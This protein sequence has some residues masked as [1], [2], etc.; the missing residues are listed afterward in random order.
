LARREDSAASSETSSPWNSPRFISNHKAR[1]RWDAV[2]KL[3]AVACVL[4]VVVPLGDLLYM[5]AYR[6][7]EVISVARLVDGTGAF[8]PGLSNA[9]VGT[10]LITGLSSLFAIPL[11]VL[12]GVYMA[13][14]SK[15]GRFTDGLRFT[16]DVLAGVPSIVLGY[17][18]YVIFVIFFGW[19]FSALAAGIILSII[20]FP[21]IFRTTEIAI[22]KVPLNIK[23][24][25]IA[26]G[27]NKTTMINRL[28]LRFA[29]PGIMTGVL[30]S[31]GIALSETAP[32]LYTA[33]FASYNPT[34]LLHS[35]VAYLTGVIWFFY[36]SSLPADVQLAYLSTFLLILIVLVLNVVARVGLSRFSK[37]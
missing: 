29:L 9:I 7:L 24:G 14:F 10:G 28:V 22:R 35:P 36:Q 25:A 16:A 11:G 23:E 1:K 3:L 26:L 13:E 32:I 27:S 30:L 21:Y 15:G 18:G 17:V 37:V 8:V 12:G 2:V 31:V 33:S 4:A 5:F 6:G 20:M 34:G 19:G